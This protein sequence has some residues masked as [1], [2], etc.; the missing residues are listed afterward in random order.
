L[1]V[2]IIQ[3]HPRAEIVLEGGIV[4]NSD[5]GGYHAGMPFPVKLIADRPGARIQVGAHSRLHGCCVH[6]WGSVH[7]GKKCLLAAGSQVL[8]AHG[9]VAGLEYGR[10][11]S[12]VQD[13][14][15]PIEIGDFCWI[16]LNAL[17]LKGVRL[18]EGCIVGAGSVVYGGDYPSFS[19]V[20]GVPA[21]VIKGI[22]PRSAL[23]EDTQLDEIDPSIGRPYTY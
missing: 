2:P 6:A 4:L 19:L 18:G 7:I 10:L 1:G 13:N 15:E 17:V 16:G 14:P 12:Q 23:A 5:T 20:A 3:V 22:D 21:R 9:H 8:D 11:R